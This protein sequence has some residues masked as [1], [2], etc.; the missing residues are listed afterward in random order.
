MRSKNNP[1]VSVSSLRKGTKVYVFYK[2]LK[3][4]EEVNWIEATVVEAGENILKCSR[5]K[6]APYDGLI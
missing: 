6:K 4:K 5:S 3:P 1:K 2:Y